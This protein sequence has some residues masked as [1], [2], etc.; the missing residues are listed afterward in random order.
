MT[1]KFN[2][3]TKEECNEFI[4]RCN[5]SI[6]QAHEMLIEGDLN[7]VKFNK[8]TKSVTDMILIRARIQAELT[9]LTN[10]RKGE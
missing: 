6:A 3:L 8:L 1:K 5:R 9:N 10:V 2:K 4:E 7:D